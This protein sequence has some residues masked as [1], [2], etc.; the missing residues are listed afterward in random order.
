MTTLHRIDDAEEAIEV[1]GKFRNR[2]LDLIALSGD[3]TTEQEILELIDTRQATMWVNGESLAITQIVID[4]D[5]AKKWCLVRH[6]IGNLSDVLAGE[7]LVDGWAKKWGA[8]G[9]CLIGR[10][11]WTKILEP[12]NFETKRIEKDLPDFKNLIAGRNYLFWKKY[13]FSTKN[14]DTDHQY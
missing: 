10:K 13:D 2:I 4:M 11:G 14:D 3:D 1:Y 9:M 6:A 5:D 8:Q 7:D 12:L